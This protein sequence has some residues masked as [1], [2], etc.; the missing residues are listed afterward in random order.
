MRLAAE[1]LLRNKRVRAN[2]TSVDLVRHQVTELH[3]IDVANHHLLIE[4]VAGASIKQ[5]RLA[6]FLDPREAFLLF[7]IVQVITNLLFLDAIEHR[8]G[9]LETE[10]FGGDAKVGLKDLADIHSTGHA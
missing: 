7:C 9:H 5:T 3:H 1:R 4:G 2:R 8:R 10:S 6:I